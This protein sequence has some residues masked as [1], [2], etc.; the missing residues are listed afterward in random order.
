MNLHVYFPSK[1]KGI[2]SPHRGSGGPA[3]TSSGNRARSSVGSLGRGT[4]WHTHRCSRRCPPLRRPLHSDRA[5]SPSTP[6]GLQQDR[7]RPGQTIE[8][9]RW[10]EIPHLYRRNAPPSRAH[11]Y[12]ARAADRNHGGSRASVR[13]AHSALRPSRGRTWRHKV[14]SL[15][16][17]QR[18]G[19]PRAK[20]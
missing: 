19:S 17:F 12:T 6:S 20:M 1:N 8:P 2:T 3:Q 10:R 9:K 13:S 11:S 4:L 18:L 7:V 5:A 14:T 15:W 16:G